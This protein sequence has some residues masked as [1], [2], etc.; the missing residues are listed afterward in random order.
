MSKP[1][2]LTGIVS[3]ALEWLW[4]H[5]RDTPN[6]SLLD[7]GGV[8][9]SAVDAIFRRGGRLFVTDLLKP[10]LDEADDYWDRTQKPAVFRANDFLSELPAIPKEN[11]SAILGWH[12]FDLLPRESLPRVVERFWSYLRTDGVLMILLREPQLTVGADTQWWLHSLDKLG[13]SGEGNRPFPYAAVTN[14]E[15]E[16]LIPNATLKTFLTRSGR[17]EVVALKK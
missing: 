3:P 2:A 6:P 10:L 9:Q 4:G 16:R 13:T 17:R 7:C 8:R 1:S 12:V 14:R 5:L 11:L 15:M